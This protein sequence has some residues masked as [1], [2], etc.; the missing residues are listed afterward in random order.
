MPFCSDCSIQLGNR[1][2]VGHL[3]STQHKNNVTMRKADVDGVVE[4]ATAFRGRISSYR[5]VATEEFENSLPDAF[6][7]NVSSKINHLLQIALN[8]HVS[9]K[10]N[11]EYYANFMLLKNNAHELKSFTTKNFIVHRNFNYDKMFQTL[12]SSIKNKI[13]EFEGRESGWTFLNNVS[14]DVNINK[15]DPL[16]GSGS[17]YIDLPLAIKKKKAC[18]NI[19][20]K[21][22]YCFLWSVVA[23]LYP[24]KNNSARVSSYPHFKSVLN[25]N[26]MSFPVTFDDISKFEN[27]NPNISIN[28]YSLKNNRTVVGPI[29]KSEFKSK[30]RIKINLLLLESQAQSHFVLIRNLS[31]LVRTQITKHHCKLY[32]CD[33]CLLFFTTEKKLN[34]HTCSGVCTVLPDKG[35][36]LQFKHFERKQDVPFVV[37]A[38]FETLLQPIEGCEPNPSS[39]YTSPR[40][41]HIPAAFAYYIVCSFDGSLN[42]FVQ[43]RGRD[44]VDKFLTKLYNDIK[45]I[46]EVLN[47]EVKMKFNDR[48]AKDFASAHV[49]HICNKPLIFDKV[50]DHCHLT[51]RYRGAAHQYCNLRYSV[52][53]LVPVFFHNL[54]GYDCHLFIKELAE[55]SG[56]VKVIPR[57]KENYVSFTKFLQLNNEKYAQ[58]RFV[59]SFQF[60]GTS[61]EK[62]AKGLHKTDFVHLKNSYPEEK[63]FELLTRKGVYPYD[64]MKHWN[65]FSERQ[66]PQKVSFYNSLTDEHISDSDYAHAQEVWSTFKIKDMGGYTDLYLKTDVLLLADI[67]ENFRQV[68]K[69]NY[70]LDPAFYLTAPSLSFDAMLLKTGVQLELLADLE[71]IRFIQKGI[72]GGICL[73]STRYAQ[74]NNKYMPY[75]DHTE[76]DSFLVYIDCNNLYGYS[77]CQ[78]L[79]VSDFRLLDQNEINLLDVMNIAD[80]AD[81]GFILEVDL[82]YPEELHYTHNDY[83]FCA[84]KFIPPGGKTPKLIPNLYSKY[85][86]VI[87]YVHLKT[88]INNGL[89]L[90]KIHRVLTFRQSSFLGEYINLNTELRKKAV[91]PFQQDLF[92]LLNNSVFGK[93]L[94][95]SEKRTDVRLVN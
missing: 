13:E 89:I 49:C 71:I 27:N 38:D 34:D 26:D 77:M 83:P 9:L 1:Q 2:W 61:L 33:D 52:P 35:A 53:K 95:D 40:Q 5:I 30:D 10:V 28:V 47:T 86:Y 88:C 43:Y 82:I 92:K 14:I 67:F 22:K 3:R 44:C 59:D 11:F 20:N 91:T 63:N 32:F 31:R 29:Y 58:I 12:V 17:T 56:P 23:A 72:R 37:Y 66:L 79:P 54:A 6:L 74:A 78:P 24:V 42:R 93:T 65:V 7:Q 16:R 80:D 73:C 55:S 48:D 19:Q 85:Q 62:L 4:F 69:S 8:R 25:T 70:Q 21:D 75:H 64:H 18:I 41:R 46:Y 39:S 36:V 50:R 60:L 68:C 81:F 84:E 90:D 94:E 15:F 76:P 45:K 87:H 51:G 57:N